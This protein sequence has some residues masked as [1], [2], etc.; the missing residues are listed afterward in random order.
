MVS[1]LHFHYYS[2]MNTS[3][4]F[5]HIQSMLTHLHIHVVIGPQNNIWSALNLVQFYIRQRDCAIPPS[6]L[7]NPG[8]KLHDAISRTR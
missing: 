8:L 7:I 4:S 1:K 6:F 3:G 5:T 2:F